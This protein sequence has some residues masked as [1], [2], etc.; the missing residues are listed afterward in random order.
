MLM[1]KSS[2]STVLHL[3][4]RYLHQFTPGFKCIF[5]INTGILHMTHKI[6]RMYAYKTKKVFQ[7]FLLVVQLLIQ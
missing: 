6:I 4:T 5:I 1:E 3:H 2:L 7:I